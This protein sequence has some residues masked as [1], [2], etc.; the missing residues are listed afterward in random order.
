M[1]L[2]EYLPVSIYELFPNIVLPFILTFTIFFAI[3]TLIKLF[4]KKI[5]LVLSL[6]F[7]F[8]AWYGGLF[9]WMTTWLAK[10]IASFAIAI[11]AVVFI[12][13]ALAWGF[14]ATKKSFYKS[15]PEK[16]LENLYK[17]REKLLKE[18]KKAR[19]KQDKE[20]MR[21]LIEQIRELDLE[22]EIA[23]R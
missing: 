1:V 7:T 20:K 8:F 3:L 14:G 11:F 22:M 4:P 12:L 17:R 9:G 21:S 16:K 6:S 2:E 5:N 13:G 18:L 15:F 19:D 10:S 23:K